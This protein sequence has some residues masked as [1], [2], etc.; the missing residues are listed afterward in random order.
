MRRKR[1]VLAAAAVLCIGVGGLVASGDGGGD[2]IEV[3]VGAEKAD[4]PSTTEG[5]RARSTVTTESSTTTSPDGSTTTT[6]APA[7]TAADA[8]DDGG[9]GGNTGPAA[10]SPT[11]GT[12][13]SDAP[14]QPPA[15]TTTTGVP[16]PLRMAATP[17]PYTPF[18]DL[19]VRSVDPCPA[20]TSEIWVLVRLVTRDGSPR[21]AGEI[22]GPVA[23]DGSWRVSLFVYAV[24]DEE[25]GISL[26]GSSAGRR[27][28]VYAYCDP[29]NVGNAEVFEKVETS[30]PVAA[31]D[32]A[33]LEVPV[34]ISAEYASATRRVTVD[35]GGCP[36][37][38][39]GL[40]SWHHTEPLGDS[41]QVTGGYATKTSTYDGTATYSVPSAF[42]P[43][44]HGLWAGGSCTDS[45]GATGVY[46]WAFVELVPPPHQR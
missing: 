39:S 4:S 28:D 46:A 11:T 12:G 34:S 35:Y 42:D 7:T 3:T 45:S 32:I 36:S 17:S 26:W 10:E 44:Q 8:G 41:Y 9:G 14:A 20:G 21:P 37:V 27:I 5:F 29:P 38:I 2:D 22:R 6:A 23:A 16:A 30:Y 24:S 31:L 25:P 15:T 40:V 19:V 18:H 43:A 1:V 13:G 33:P